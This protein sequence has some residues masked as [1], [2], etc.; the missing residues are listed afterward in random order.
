MR[1]KG[2]D[3]EPKDLLIY[4]NDLYVVRRLHD[5]ELGESLVL[6]LHLPRDG[7][8]EFTIP[9]AAIGTKDEC[10]KYVAQNGVAV[11]NVGAIQEYLMKWV[12]NFAVHI[13]GHGIS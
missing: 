7:V 13:G 6:R 9:L 5:P 1:G 12:N 8:R 2:E 4:A 11:L 10:R 3:D